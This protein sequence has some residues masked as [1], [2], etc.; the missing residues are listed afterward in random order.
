MLTLYN[1]P[2]SGNCY[3]ARLMLGLL[4]LEATIRDVDYENGALGEDWFQAINPLG[5]VPVLVDDGPVGGTLVLRDSQAILIYLARAYGAGRWLP[6][7]PALQASVLQWLFF[8]ATEIQAGPRMARAIAVRGIPGDLAAAQARAR[9]AL[10]I[11]DA[12][13]AGRDWL[14]TGA[15]TVADVAC[16]PYVHNAHQGHID[17]AAYPHLT[18]WL[19]RVERLDGF[20]DFAA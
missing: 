2:T 17:M 12:R 6:E 9:H 3:R 11:L 19:R 16:Y 13:L 4:G 8:A 10:A 1:I 14:E 20:V 7:A 18:A 15:P 5:E